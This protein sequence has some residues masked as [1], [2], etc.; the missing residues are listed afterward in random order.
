MNSSVRQCGFP[1][2]TVV[3]NLTIM[4]FHMAQF[5]GLVLQMFNHLVTIDQG[6]ADELQ[7]TQAQTSQV[8]VQL[9]SLINNIMSGEVP[10]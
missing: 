10:W 8:R 4:D 9:Q 1:P 3:L 6:A 7:K 5:Q 2:L